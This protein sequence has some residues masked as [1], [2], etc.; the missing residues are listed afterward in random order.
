MDGQAPPARDPPP[1]LQGASGAGLITQQ[2]EGLLGFDQ[3][4]QGQSPTDGPAEFQLIPNCPPRSGDG[5]EPDRHDSLMEW[6]RNPSPQGRL[7]ALGP[8]RGQA[9][10]GNLPQFT[11]G[12]RATVT[13]GH[14][15]PPGFGL[16]MDPTIGNLS[17]R[18]PESPIPVTRRGP[19][20]EDPEAV[21]ASSIIQPRFRCYPTSRL[22]D[23]RPLC[24]QTTAMSSASSRECDRAAT[25]R[26]SQAGLRAGGVRAS[27][28]LPCS[29]PLR[30]RVVG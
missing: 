2:L 6:W 16:T 24:R 19:A 17:R 29:I 11:T 26:R 15:A 9:P 4:N 12:D 20:R 10:E 7:Q 13:M 22:S 5:Q 14:D 8:A 27:R 21:H 1:G 25:W 23:L 18:R 3:T 28:D 30:H